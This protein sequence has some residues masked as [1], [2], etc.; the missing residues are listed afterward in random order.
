MRLAAS[1]KSTGSCSAGPGAN[2][3]MMGDREWRLEDSMIGRYARWASR[4][5]LS[6]G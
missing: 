3:A 6:I 5:I 2:A 1:P 4:G